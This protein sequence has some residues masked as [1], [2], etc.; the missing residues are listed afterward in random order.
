MHASDASGRVKAKKK[1]KVKPLKVND[2]LVVVT[3]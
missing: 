2:R 3:T 1:G